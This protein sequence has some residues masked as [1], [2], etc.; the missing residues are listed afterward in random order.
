MLSTVFIAALLSAA[1]ASAERTLSLKVSAPISITDVDNLVVKAT[2]SNT[3]DETLKLLNDPR[4]PLSTWATDSWDITD[5]KG[6]SPKFTGV[7]VRYAPSV[8]VK[9]GNPKDF[10]ILAPGA[11]VEIEHDLAGVYN[12]TTEGK[13]DFQVANLF[14]IVEKDGSIS[15]IYADSESTQIA[16]SGNLASSKNV[17]GNVS[18]LSKR[19]SYRSCSTTRQ[20]QI[21]SA[22]TAA[23]SAATESY[24]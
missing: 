6:R 12:F 15:T 8:A 22:I 17:V 1:V 14:S 2:I 13:Y 7:K 9:L 24:K 16:I 10:T 11:S 20:S 5:A 19:A 21:A 4:S 3:G 18:N 23:Q